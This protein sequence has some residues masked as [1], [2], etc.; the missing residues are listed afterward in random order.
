MQNSTEK[1]KRRSLNELSKKEL[2]KA[3]DEDFS[4]FIRMSAANDNGYICCPTCGKTYHWKKMDCSHYI[5]RHEH[6]VRW[7][8]RNVIAQCQ[9][10]NRYQSGNIWK[11]RRVLVNRHG[12]KAVE[13]VEML[14]DIKGGVDVIWLL[15]KIKYYRAKNK[16]LRKE[17][18]L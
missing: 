10:E 18:N 13:Q 1:K 4:V 12:E 15:E 14:A 6:A 7:D 8:E 16:P 3:L 9:S 17:K 5:S 11:L 2:I